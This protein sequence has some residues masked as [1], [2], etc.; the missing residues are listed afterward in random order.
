MKTPRQINDERERSGFPRLNF[1]LFR[2]VI[3]QLETHPE[4]YDQDTYE[5]NTDCGSV[6]CIGG[7]GAY[8]SHI[9]IWK[10]GSVQFKQIAKAFGIVEYEATVLFSGST[11]LWPEKYR[12]QWNR[13]TSG[14]EETRV[15]IRY[16][17]HIIKTGKVTE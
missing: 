4:M 8:F 17:T 11:V 9:P 13:A 12:L 2:R 1:K 6:R 7:W 3:R 14:K 5:T 15:A 16:L 10:K